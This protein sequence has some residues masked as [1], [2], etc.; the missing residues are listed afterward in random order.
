MAFRDREMTKIESVAD[1]VGEDVRMKKTKVKA[2]RWGGRERE[3]ERENAKQTFSEDKRMRQMRR[4]H[5]I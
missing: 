1:I 4:A 3:R 5:K 2:S